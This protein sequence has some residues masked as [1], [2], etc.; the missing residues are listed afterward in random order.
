MDVE[1]RA[2]V[3]S[4]PTAISY[5]LVNR[6]LP[7]AGSAF[8]WS[9]KPTSPAVGTWVDDDGRPVGPPQT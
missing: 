5:A 9:W 3:V 7:S 8:T 6:E 2:L 4:L 1:Q